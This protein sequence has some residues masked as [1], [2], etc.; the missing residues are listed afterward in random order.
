MKIFNLS[1]R[2][3]EREKERKREGNNELSNFDVA[4]IHAL[5]YNEIFHSHHHYL[6]LY[7]DKFV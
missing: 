7:L 1:K 4:Q 6:C 2:E 3:E 5:K